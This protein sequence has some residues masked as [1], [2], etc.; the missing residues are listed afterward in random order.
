M[1]RRSDRIASVIGPM[2]APQSAPV[3]YRP[4]RDMWV[5]GGMSKATPPTAAAEVVAV[6]APE[7]PAAA[8]RLP[9]D[10]AA[11]AFV[12]WLGRAYPGVVESFLEAL[13][14]DQ[15]IAHGQLGAEGEQ[16]LVQKMLDLAQGI[17]PAYLQYKQQ[18]E[19]LS[20]QLERAKA[21]LPPLETGQFAPSVQIGLD[22][23]TIA[24]MADEATHRAA[25]VAGSPLPWLIGAGA[26]VAVLALRN[27]PRRRR[28]A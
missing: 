13:G 9:R 18:D 8:D 25:S 10:E 3:V 27:K 5:W 14:V 19:V 28:S 7:P 16:T 17:L 20:I 22:Q 21:G 2:G 23:E 4:T 24:R 26:L 11:A 12:D 1:T 15:A 6:H